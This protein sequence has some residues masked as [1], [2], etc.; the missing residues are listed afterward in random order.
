M[1]KFVKADHHIY[2]NKDEK[3]GVPF[4]WSSEHK[5]MLRQLKIKK[6]QAYRRI[7]AS[8]PK[9][10]KEILQTLKKDF[11]HRYDDFK[12]RIRPTA[13][14]VNG[15]NIMD[16][17]DHMRYCTEEA[18]VWNVM[19]SSYR[20]DYNVLAKA[21]NERRSAAASHNAA[22][23]NKWSEMLWKRD[24]D[25]AYYKVLANKPLESD[26]SSDEEEK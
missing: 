11:P 13:G 9:N 3:S 17:V 10:K 25:A 24:V 19:P 16:Q 20:W 15:R 6:P 1:V 23:V 18:W 26:S 14:R 22:K 21:E 5:W 2:R 4:S 7:K 12:R 8:H